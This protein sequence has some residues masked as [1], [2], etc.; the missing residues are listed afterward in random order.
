MSRGSLGQCHMWRQLEEAGRWPDMLM[1][2]IY[3]E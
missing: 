3:S 1:S 2:V